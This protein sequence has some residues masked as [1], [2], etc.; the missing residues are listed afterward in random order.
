MEYS[1]A[2]KR[3]VAVFNAPKGSVQGKMSFMEMK[4]VE[5]GFTKEWAMT[6]ML[7][8]LNKATDGELLRQI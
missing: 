1:E 5:A 4:L 3:C 2:V 8:A 7:E 6:V